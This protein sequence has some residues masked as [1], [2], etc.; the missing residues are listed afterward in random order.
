MLC[1]RLSKLGW[2]VWSGLYVGADLATS[3][4]VGR[5]NVSYFARDEGGD[6]FAFTQRKGAL[7]PVIESR[8]ALGWKGPIAQGLWLTAEAG[9]EFQ[10]WIGAARRP[11]FTGDDS[12]NQLVREKDNLFLHGPFVQLKLTFDNLGRL[13]AW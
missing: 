7:V 10:S 3:L 2:N 11:A 8:L 4:L 6:R 1:P 13:F 5:F 12:E 9:Y